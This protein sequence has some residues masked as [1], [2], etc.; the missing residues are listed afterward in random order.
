MKVVLLLVA[1]VLFILMAAFVLFRQFSSDSNDIAGRVVE[2]EL[3]GDSYNPEIKKS[4]SAKTALSGS[5]GGSGGGSVEETPGGLAYYCTEEQKQVEE[6]S[7][8]DHPVCGWFDLTKIECNPEEPCVRS[9][10]P[11]V[12][13][14]CSVPQILYW[15]EG[16][17]PLH[18]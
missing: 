10:F 11:N 16:D 1:S 13:E 8:E 6:C 12:C 14:A 4:A 18:S 9:V 15:T 3:V 5:G 17:C 2:G 7:E